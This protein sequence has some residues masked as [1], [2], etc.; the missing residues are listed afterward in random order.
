MN[1]LHRFDYCPQLK[2]LYQNRRATGRSGKVF[3]GLGALSTV[4]NLIFIRSLMLELKPTCTLEVGM[5]FGGSALAFAATHKELGRLPTEQHTAIDPAQ[6]AYWDDAGRI[7]LEEA[8]LD[9]FVEV[10]EA[11]SSVA[12]PKLVEEKRIYG[13]AYIDGSHQ[14][15]D[16]LLDFFYIHQM[17]EIGGVML[18]DDSTDSQVAKV[19]RFI[20]TNYSEIYR[21]ISLARFKNG[22]KAQV[23]Y[24]IANRLR[25]TQLSGYLKIREGRQNWGMPLKKF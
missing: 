18:F 8:G 1:A 19:L 21:S 20:E 4:N 7:N 22:F 15:E 14:F 5:A 2:S 23:K 6:S 17:L 10:I 12:L 16:V 9:G 13:L 25:K 11:Y 24:S 3:E